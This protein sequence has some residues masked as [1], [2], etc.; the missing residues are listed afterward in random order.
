M[1]HLFNL[2][3][4]LKQVLLVLTVFAFWNTG[5][6]Q[7]FTIKRIEQAPEHF[8]IYYDLES[9]EGSNACQVQVFSSVDNFLKPLEKVTGDVGISVK[10]GVNRRIIWDIKSE[11]GTKFKGEVQLEIRGKIYVPFIVMN[12]LEENKV[13]KRAKKTTFTWTGDINNKPLVF[14]LYKD[15]ELISERSEIPNIGSAVIILPHSVKPGHGYYFVITETG[16][17][18][19]SIRTNEFIIK[20]KIP[21]VIKVIPVAIVA[22]VVIILLP[23]KEPDTVGEPIGPPTQKK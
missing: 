11:Y 18:E 15:N 19:H 14:S 16:N 23:D 3:L 12:N 22:G 2:G 9:N 4:K 7:N 1:K 10:P 21:A 8:I 20:K 17:S 13:I 5:G 6:S